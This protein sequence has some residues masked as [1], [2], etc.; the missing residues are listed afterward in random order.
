MTDSTK[1]TYNSQL[2]PTQTILKKWS[3]L[4]H[5]I[6]DKLGTEPTVICRKLYFDYDSEWQTKYYAIHL[7]MREIK[8]TA[9]VANR[10]GMTGTIPE[11]ASLSRVPAKK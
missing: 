4:V 5:L 8:L 9:T 10:P 6:A 7:Y 2:F 1:W 11:R 3:E